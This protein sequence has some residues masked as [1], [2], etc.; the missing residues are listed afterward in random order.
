MNPGSFWIQKDS[1]IG[2]S[3]WYFLFNINMISIHISSA[4]VKIW[5][6]MSNLA[7]SHRGE[8]D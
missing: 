5:H 8:E 4:F 6:K 2:I 1:W 7:S 3:L